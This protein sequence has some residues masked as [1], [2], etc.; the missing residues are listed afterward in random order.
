MNRAKIHDVQPSEEASRPPRSGWVGTIAR[1]VTRRWFGKPC[2]IACAFGL[3]ALL[4]LLTPVSN[5]ALAQAGY[6]HALSGQASTQDAAEQTALKVGDV[7]R[8]GTSV[9]TGERGRLVLKL[10]DGQLLALGPDSALRLDR[11]QYDPQNLK[12]SSSSVGLVRGSMRVVTG[13]IAVHNR[14]AVRVSAGSSSIIPSS[15][16]GAD[17][18]VVV[19]TKDGEAG[20]VAVAAGEIAMNTPSGITRVGADQTVPWRAGIEQSPA[21]MP[22]AAS[23]AVIQAAVAALQLAALPAN[24][25]PEVTAV[26]RAARSEAAA[27]SSV[28]IG[29]VEAVSGQLS[30]KRGNNRRV[31]KAGDRFAE[32]TSFETSE[33]GRVALKFTDGMSVRLGAKSSLSVDHYTFNPRDITVSG[34]EMTLISGSI[35]VVAGSMAS[36]DP[37]AAGI[38]VGGSYLTLL[39]AGGADFGVVFNPATQAGGIGAAAVTNGEIGVQTPYGLT[40][41]GVDQTIPWQSGGGGPPPP[42]VVA[43]L[44]QQF[45]AE[46]AELQV[47]T[48]IAAALAELPATAAGPDPAAQVTFAP[49]PGVYSAFTVTPAVT[50]CLGSPC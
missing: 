49:L 37:Q 35:R 19:D 30:A 31:L 22:L 10:A 34:F 21:P 40:R 50:G 44:L 38:K 41:I 45:Q 5:D 28:P 39:Q 32:G 36:Q 7:F 33:T 47:G 3:L 2:G 17:F 18:S 23:P 8:F 14:N 25:P 15:D 42:A 24:T 6:V 48:N 29:Y 26:A 27:A 46:L 16:K 9:T 4:I 43:A 12:A 20:V 13:S 11:Y 1:G